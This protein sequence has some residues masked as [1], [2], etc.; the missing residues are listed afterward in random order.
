[1]NNNNQNTKTS[2]NLLPPFPPEIENDFYISEVEAL[3]HWK[4]G[5]QKYY[6]IKSST[7]HENIK[8]CLSRH[9]AFA[10]IN[11]LQSS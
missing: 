10:Y 11:K 2:A 1:M 3:L 6:I 9:D 8:T 4:Y 7:T 5:K